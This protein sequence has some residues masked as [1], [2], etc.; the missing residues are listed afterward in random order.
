VG[1]RAK[2]GQPFYYGGQAVLEGVMMRGQDAWSL[3]VRRPKGEIYLE[4]HQLTPL[5][6]RVRLFRLP[7]FRGVGV[8]VDSLA[9]GVR[10]LAISGNQALEEDEQL[11]DRQMGW[12]LGLGAA[13]FTL[14][15]ILAPAA[16]TN[17]L[18]SHLPSN[19]VFNLV[20]GVARLAF[21]L[22]YILLISLLKDIRRVF[23]YHGAEHKAIHCY[24]AGLPL[25]PGN[26]DRFPT[27]HVRCGTN[28]LLILFMVTLVL[29]TVAFSLAGRP[30]LL[31]RVPLQILAVPVI[32]GIAY[33]GIRLGAGRERSALVRAL[34]KPG[35]WLQMLT[36]KP[37]TRDMIEVAIRSLEQVLPPAERAKV[38]PLPSRLAAGPG[39]ELAP[40]DEPASEDLAKG[41]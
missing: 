34:M 3:A 21:F 8:L 36:T 14:L 6:K 28:F 20:E 23:Q 22:G 39:A 32:V 13:F 1:D 5:G 19:L 9:I 26:V 17:W 33:E 41:G 15:F 16:G 27:L 25:E 29:F 24:E 11:T 10:A 40:S 18:S 35:L 38:A 31:V 30:P 12:S 7:F 2:G 4:K 37:P